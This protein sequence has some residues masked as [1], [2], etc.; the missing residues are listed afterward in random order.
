MGNP[1]LPSADAQF[2]APGLSAQNCKLSLKL[3]SFSL[4]IF[5]P[6][7]FPPSLTL[8]FNFNLQLNC[9]LSN[10]IDL[11]GGL[12]FGGGRIVC[13]DPDPDLE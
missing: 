11:S 6:F 12:A 13:A 4:A 8:A 10:P 2:D 1:C 3:P 5:L 7:A 9:D